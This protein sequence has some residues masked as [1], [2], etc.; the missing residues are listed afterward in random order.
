[1]FKEPF[2]QA[3]YNV[4]RVGGC[5]Q[6]CAM[7]SYAELCYAMLNTSVSFPQ[8]QFQFVELSANRIWSSFSSILKFSRAI[9]GLEVPRVDHVAGRVR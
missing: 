9:Q 8:T 3:I 4:D 7:L 6:S 1:M 5:I 2:S